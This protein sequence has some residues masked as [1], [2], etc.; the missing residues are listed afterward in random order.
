MAA[1][2]L[3]HHN[4]VVLNGA[5][6]A[7]P[8]HRELPSGTAVAE[9]DLTTRGSSG[10]VSVPVSWPSPTALAELLHAGDEVLVIGTVRR[11]FFRAGGTTASRT[12]VVPLRVALRRPERRRALSA[13]AAAV[14]AQLAEHGGAP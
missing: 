11:R 13:A 10:T 14:D 12:E 6:A 4:L 3:D 7:D 9:F 1:P 2:P 5:L 8:R